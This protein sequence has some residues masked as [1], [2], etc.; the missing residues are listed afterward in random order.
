MGILVEGKEA[1][2]AIKLVNEGKFDKEIKEEKTELT[3]EELKSLEEERKSLEAEAKE[4]IEKEEA[5]AQKIIA[6]MVGKERGIIKAKLVELGIS[7]ET[8]D[9]LLPV[10][11]VAPTAEGAPAPTS[12]KK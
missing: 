2:E 12:E 5:T 6:E 4:R 8:I 9:K 3:A 7:K 10:E 11:G 1:A